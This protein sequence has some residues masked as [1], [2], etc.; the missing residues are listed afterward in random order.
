MGSGE[1]EIVGWRDER[2]TCLISHI[3][4]RIHIHIHIMP[5]VRSTRVTS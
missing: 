4:I 5:H 1:G 2:M 3:H